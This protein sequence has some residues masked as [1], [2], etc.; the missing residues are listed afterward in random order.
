MS[1]MFSPFGP[2]YTGY[3]SPEVYSAF[4]DVQGCPLTEN[5]CEFMPSAEQGYILT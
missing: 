2:Q 5:I 4:L 1:T 3:L